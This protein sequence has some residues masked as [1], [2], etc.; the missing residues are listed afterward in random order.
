MEVVPGRLPLCHQFPAPLLRNHPVAGVA[1][2]RPVGRRQDGHCF[3]GVGFA[4]RGDAR[5]SGYVVE[6]LDGLG[7]VGDPSAVGVHANCIVFHNC[8]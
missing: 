6:E 2:A 4:E 5:V 8:N 7:G 3:Y 1:G